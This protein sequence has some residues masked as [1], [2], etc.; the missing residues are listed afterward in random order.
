MAQPDVN[1]KLPYKQWKVKADNQRQN[2][3]VAP[4]CWLASGPAASLSADFWR[5]RTGR[6]VCWSP[7]TITVRTTIPTLDLWFRQIAQLA[8]WATN[9]HFIFRATLHR[10]FPY[11]AQSTESVSTTNQLALCFPRAS[12]ARLA[13]FT[14][15]TGVCGS[16]NTSPCTA[17]IRLACLPTDSS[18]LPL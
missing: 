17:A 3:A 9:F 2:P 13:S 11:S 18:L 1:T 12:L 7:F 5:S 14:G 10:L 8:K 4:S 15:A 16:L 6:P